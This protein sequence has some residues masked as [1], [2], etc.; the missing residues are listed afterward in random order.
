MREIK[1]LGIKSAVVAVPGSKSYTHRMLI[2]AALSD[3]RCLLQN[4]LDSEDTRYTRR[5]L[6][7]L[8]LR[9]E[10]GGNGQEG[11]TPSGPPRRS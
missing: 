5:A 2:A 6:R 8:G 1:P 7:Q 10:D 4:C 11:L 9:I 3:G